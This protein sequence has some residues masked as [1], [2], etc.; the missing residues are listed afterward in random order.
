MSDT[1]SKNNTGHMT[2]KPDY[3]K[4]HDNINQCIKDVNKHESEIVEESDLSRTSTSWIHRIIHHVGAVK[5]QNNDRDFVQ[6]FM[7]IK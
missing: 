5:Q 1:N 4:G 6:S 2:Y 3:L 7:Q